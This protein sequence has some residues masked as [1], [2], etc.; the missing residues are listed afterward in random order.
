VHEKRHSIS[1]RAL[2]GIAPLLIGGLVLGATIGGPSATA[3]AQDDA[4]LRDVGVIVEPDETL[5]GLLAA[6]ADVVALQP[7]ELAPLQDGQVGYIING[8]PSEA[9]YVVEE[10]LAGFGANTAIGRTNAFIGQ[11]VLDEHG[12]P[13]SCSR[14]DVDMRTLQSDES[15]RD[16]FLRGN[17]LQ[18]DQ[19]PVATFVLRAVEGLEGA[20]TAEVQA[21]TLIGDLVF[22]EQTQLVAWEATAALDGGQLMGTAFT[23]FDMTDFDIE[24]PI[25][26]SVVSIDDTVR[27]EVD[28][29]AQQA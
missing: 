20:L 6:C 8:E 10:E 1:K 22:R 7:G 12:M 24:K 18:S 11:I 23:E 5:A 16:N 19:Y 21:F 25:V 13:A 26:G 14:F 9:R 3:L 29:A 17:T 4:A 28:I 15:R 2:L 27:L